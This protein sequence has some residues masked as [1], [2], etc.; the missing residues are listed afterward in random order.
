LAAGL[1]TRFGVY[2]AG[3]EPAKDPK[4]MVAPQLGRLRALGVVGR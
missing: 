2:S 4:H 3:V 1:H